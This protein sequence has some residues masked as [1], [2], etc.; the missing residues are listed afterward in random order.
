MPGAYTYY[1]NK[2]VKLFNSET[3]MNDLSSILKPGEIVY[4][5]PYLQVGTGTGNIHIHEIQLEDKKRLRVSQFI[6]GYPQIQ[7]GCFG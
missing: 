5:K 1:S 2:R 6:T 7:E 3:N 4:C